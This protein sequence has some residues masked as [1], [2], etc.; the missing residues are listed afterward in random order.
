[1]YTEKQGVKNGRQ[2]LSNGLAVRY[3]NTGFYE[4][5]GDRGS[6]VSRKAP[7]VHPYGGGVNWCTV[8][9]LLVTVQLS[10]PMGPLGLNVAL[11]GT[12]PPANMAPRPHLPSPISGRSTHPCNHKVGEN[13]E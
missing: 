11:V 7:P 2:H 13:K 6:G 1:M 3:G 10:A 4:Q 5:V 12:V 8:D 9:G